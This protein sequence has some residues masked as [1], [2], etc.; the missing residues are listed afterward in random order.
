[1]GTVDKFL[2]SKSDNPLAR[3]PHHVQEN[4]LETTQQNRIVLIISFVDI[5]TLP[6][7]DS[8]KRR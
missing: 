4:H 3:Y 5:Q 6:A 1:M 2:F 8:I 7:L